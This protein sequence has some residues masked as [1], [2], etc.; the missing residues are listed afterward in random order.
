MTI[1]EVF[2]YFNQIDCKHMCINVQQIDFKEP[3]NDDKAYKFAFNK[4]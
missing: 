2:D 4:V 3:F 1:K